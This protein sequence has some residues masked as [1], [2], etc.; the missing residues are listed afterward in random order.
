MNFVID[1]AGIVDKERVVVGIGKAV[2]MAIGMAD[3]HKNILA[4]LE[5]IGFGSTEEAKL[6]KA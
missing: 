5:D 4:I 1:S 2:G 6:A 3:F